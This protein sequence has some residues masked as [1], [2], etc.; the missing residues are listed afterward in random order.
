MNYIDFKLFCVYELNSK[1]KATISEIISKDYEDS[2]DE[3]VFEV[4]IDNVRELM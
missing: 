3:A 4:C 1:D 2:P